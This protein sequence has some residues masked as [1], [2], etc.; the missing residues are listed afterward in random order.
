MSVTALS[1]GQNNLITML[2][3]YTACDIA[4]ALL[5]LHVSN[6]G[7]LS[8]LHLI[9]RPDVT[10]TSE[11]SPTITIAPAST[12]TFGPI[13]KSSH[14][15]VTY[16][17]TNIPT[18]KHWVDL[19]L[20]ETI[21]VISQPEGQS[22]AVL[23]GILALRLK[24]LNVKGVVV[25]GRIRDKLELKSTGLPIW[26]RGTSIV[27]SSAE[28]KPLAIQETLNIAGTLVTPG[29]IIFCDSINGVVVIPQQRVE[30]VVDLLPALTAADERV[31]ND[32]RNGIL[33]SEAFAKHRS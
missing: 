2:A 8:N 17:Q 9:T 33:V 16:P 22:C 1:Q 26:A 18:G 4:D 30:E 19:T 13:A 29:D 5:K 23:G 25:S 28:S 7:Y 14:D 31:K 32:V 12:M 27:G 3:E 11:I 20:S 24:I 6:A 21:L 15:K 10:S